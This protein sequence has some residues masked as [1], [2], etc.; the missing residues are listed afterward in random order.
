MEER[1]G[2]VCLKRKSILTKRR[3]TMVG[4]K[5]NNLLNGSAVP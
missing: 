4:S 1:I 3:H 2:V 5:E